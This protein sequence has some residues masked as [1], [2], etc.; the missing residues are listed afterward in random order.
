LRAW[1][2]DFEHQVSGVQTPAMPIGTMPRA[3]GSSKFEAGSY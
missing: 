2:G 1:A 3:G